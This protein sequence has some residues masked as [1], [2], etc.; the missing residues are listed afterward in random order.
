LKD[1]QIAKELFK[2]RNEALYASPINKV[3][4][5]AFEHDAAT[6]IEYCEAWLERIRSQEAVAERIGTK[7][8]LK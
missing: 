3:D 2:H 6:L 5:A 8:F 7:A 1:D 4:D